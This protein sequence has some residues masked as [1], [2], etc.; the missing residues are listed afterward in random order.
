MNLLQTKSLTVSIA[1][2]P[3][4]NDLSVKM[5]RGECWTIL[6]GNGA[7]KTTLL[8]TFAGLRIA[9]KGQIDFAGKLLE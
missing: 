6:G 3:I 8:H 1:G 2:K 5:Q 9:D 4:C 7:G